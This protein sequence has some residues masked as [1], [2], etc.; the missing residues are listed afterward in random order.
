MVVVSL[1]HLFVLVSLNESKEERS[2]FSVSL[3]RTNTYSS[4]PGTKNGQ[5]FKVSLSTGVP[6]SHPIVS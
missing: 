4:L 5:T 6:L 2:A 1:Y 3:T